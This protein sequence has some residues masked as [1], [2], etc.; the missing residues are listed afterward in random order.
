MF[1][2]ALK[3][4]QIR[5]NFATT[6]KIC[7]C[8]IYDIKNWVPL[9]KGVPCRV[10]NSDL[11]FHYLLTILP[12]SV[13]TEAAFMAGVFY[14]IN[15]FFGQILLVSDLRQFFILNTAHILVVYN[16]SSQ[17]KPCIH[18]PKD[19]LLLNQFSEVDNTLKERV[20]HILSLYILYCYCSDGIFFRLKHFEILDTS[21]I[22]MPEIYLFLSWIFFESN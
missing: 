3:K 22:N 12:T 5:W 15:T 11:A 4:K 20:N 16:C 13:G 10:L 17:S 14:R 2:D 21:I 7:F 1:Q 8:Q 9:K 18:R 19:L 6:Y